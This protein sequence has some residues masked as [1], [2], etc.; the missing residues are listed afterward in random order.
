MQYLKTYIFL[1][2]ALALTSCKS[3]QIVSSWVQPEKEIKIENLSKVLVVALFHNETSRRK[4]E[5]QMVGYLKGKGIVS[6]NYLDDAFNKNN[7]EAIRKVIK[8]DN[9][10]A[11]ITMRLI[12]VDREQ[13]YIPGNDRLNAPNYYRNFS[14]YYN[15]N[16]P[17]YYQRGYYANTKT[18]TVETVVFSITQD[19][20]IW[21]GLTKTTNPDGLIKMTEEIAQVV[22]KKM[23]KQ[24]FVN[25]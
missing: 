13:V 21:S 20:I 1:L 17:F 24:G 5:D 22:F 9:F 4:A 10:D 19:K 7:E 16:Y 14:G 15:R 23:I 2:F 18:Y 8:A 6:Y 3:T 25:K 12:D 11:A